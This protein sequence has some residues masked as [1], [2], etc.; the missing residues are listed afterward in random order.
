MIGENSDA[1]TSYASSS[2][3]DPPT[4]GPSRLVDETPAGNHR[5]GGML[6]NR[7]PQAS[8]F[9]HRRSQTAFDV[10]NFNLEGTRLRHQAGDGL[11][12]NECGLG[13]GSLGRHQSPKSSPRKRKGHKGGDRCVH[14][15]RCCCHIG[16]FNVHSAAHTSPSGR[17]DSEDEIGVAL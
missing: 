16:T 15:D 9:N 12:L 1:S 6:L 13:L 17:S 11:F 3:D 7:P 4:A 14:F 5:R 10:F 8:P 2:R